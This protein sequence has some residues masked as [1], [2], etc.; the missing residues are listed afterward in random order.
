V[1][2]PLQ[3]GHSSARIP[4]VATS[5]PGQQWQPKEQRRVREKEALQE[6]PWAIK[7]EISH[8][9]KQKRAENWAIVGL[10]PT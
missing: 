1:L 6:R 5:W 10:K 4:S 2:S 3:Q 7:M 9:Q 8:G